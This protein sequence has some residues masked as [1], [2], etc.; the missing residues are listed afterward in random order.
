MCLEIPNHRAV[1]RRTA[2]GLRVTAVGSEIVNTNDAWPVHNWQWYCLQ[3]VEY[4][5]STSQKL[6][7]KTQPSGCPTA[8]FDSH[9]GQ[10]VP[11]PLCA[12]SMNDWVSEP[13]AEDAL[14]TSWCL[15]TETFNAQLEQLGLFSNW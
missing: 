8:Q 14:R 10:G 9:A 1:Y 15:A 6:Q 3:S 11:L 2:R 7:L 12:T 13:L 4:G 5:G